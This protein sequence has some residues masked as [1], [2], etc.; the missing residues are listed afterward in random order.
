VYT[1]VLLE[2]DKFGSRF[3]GFQNYFKSRDLNK[4]VTATSVSFLSNLE[5]AF[6]SIKR[7]PLFGSGL[8][9]HSEMYTLYFKESAFKYSYLYGTNSPSG[10][11]LLIRIL[12]EAGLMGFL[13]VGWGLFKVTLLRADNYHRIISLACIAHFF[14][15]ALKLGGYFDY[16][17]PFFAM[18]LV[19]NYWDYKQ[20]LKK[21]ATVQVADN[22]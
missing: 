5:V 14:G 19:F 16:G 6:E 15:K 9:G 1:N 10:H 18:I 13:A 21:T 7:N 2:Y 22:E 20:S 11:S 8:G 4:V 12:S 3:L 17:T